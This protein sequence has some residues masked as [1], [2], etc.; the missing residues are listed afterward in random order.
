MTTNQYKIMNIDIISLFKGLFLTP[1]KQT[2]Y[3]MCEFCISIFRASA[4]Y[5]NELVMQDDV[6]KQEEEGVVCDWGRDRR[7]GQ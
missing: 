3:E 2:R 1:L 4:V 7:E 5:S 6:N